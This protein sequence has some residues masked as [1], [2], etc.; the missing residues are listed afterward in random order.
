MTLKRKEWVENMSA[1]LLI[2]LDFKDNSVITFFL[3]LSENIPCDHSLEPSQRDGSYEQSQKV[4][5][6]GEI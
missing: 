4:C 1:G 6:Y 2:R 5:F 3:F